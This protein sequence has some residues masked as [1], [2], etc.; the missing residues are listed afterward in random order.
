MNDSSADI[1]LHKKAALLVSDLADY[2]LANVD[3]V[4]LP[5]FNNRL[6]LKSVVGLA[7]STDLDLQE[8][9]SSGLWLI[10]I[11]KVTDEMIKNLNSK[12][13]ES[14][15]NSYKQIHKTGWHSFHKLF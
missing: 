14:K 8:K 2:Q 6:L 3:N 12:T 13:T 11:A 9:V 7:S 1:R 10:C 15:N 4:K 5:F